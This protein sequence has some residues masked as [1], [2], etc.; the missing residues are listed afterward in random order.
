MG[1][2]YIY[3]LIDPRTN[4]IRYIGKANHISK[5]YYA[6]IHRAK[7]SGNERSHVYD[8]IRSL[9]K[10]DL[11]PI[12]IEIDEVLESEWEFW[13]QHYISLYRSWG[14]KLTNHTEGGL[15]N[16]SVVVI[17]QRIV[18][19]KRITKPSKKNIQAIHVETGEVTEYISIAECARQLGTRSNK[20]ED[21]L[22][23]G[24]RSRLVKGYLFRDLTISDEQVIY[25]LYKDNSVFVGIAY[26]DKLQS[27]IKSHIVYSRT[28]KNTLHNWLQNNQDYQIEILES[29]QE[30][31]KMDK[32]IEYTEHFTS[33]NYEV[34]N[35]RINNCKRVILNP[36]LI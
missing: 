5:R 17:R 12:V 32:L 29:A 36:I 27:T 28:R 20:I 21:S 16:I 30:S 18:K 26:K 1:Y 34:L 7:T 22:V 23:S 14:F 10:L 9:L 13:E 15:T 24:H 4:K 3:A 25:K 2:T 8:W 19:E 31:N 11:K 6:H 33:N 35:D